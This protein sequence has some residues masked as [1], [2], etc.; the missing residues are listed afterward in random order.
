MANEPRSPDAG[1]DGEGVNGRAGN[2]LVGGTPV[3]PPLVSAVGV[4]GESAALASTARARRASMGKNSGARTVPESAEVAG[5]VAAKKRSE[6][7]SSTTPSP[8]PVK[9]GS[10]GL[11]QIADG[12]EE[13][14]K[15]ARQ[16]V[17]VWESAFGQKAGSVSGMQAKMGADVE[18]KLAKFCSE[19]WHLLDKHIADLVRDVTA[20]LTD[21]TG[22]RS[23][24]STALKKLRDEHWDGN[25]WWITALTRLMDAFSKASRA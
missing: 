13:V 23:R 16:M 9:T 14:S 10:M 21:P 15:I 18:K 17:D 6:A 5:I 4:V 22:D 2:V 7:R 11:R 12:E 3:P 19:E 20:G 1:Y 24:A 8:S 25:A